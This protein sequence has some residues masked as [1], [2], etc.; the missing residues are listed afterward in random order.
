MAPRSC[1]SAIVSERA[2]VG[3]ARLPVAVR[4]GAP[5]RVAQRRA[6]PGRPAELLRELAEQ[7]L[8]VQIAARARDLVSQHA[9]IGEV[10]EQRDDVG[11]RLV[12]GGHVGVARLV[13]ARMHAVEQRVRGFVRDD[14][15]RQA[16]ED[17]RA[18]RVVGVLRLTGK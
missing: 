15:V 10:L 5:K 16:G 18:R 12:E 11:E 14:V 6:P 9:R 17:H 4:S 8:A 3:L 1:G 13:E 2:R 7:V